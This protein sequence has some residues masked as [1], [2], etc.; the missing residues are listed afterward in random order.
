M[1][2][3]AE[4]RSLSIVCFARTL[5]TAPPGHFETLAELKCLPQSGHRCAEACE[6]GIP[7]QAYWLSSCWTI[8]M[9]H[10]ADS[11]IAEIYAVA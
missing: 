9:H 10:I 2:P 3:F 5:G 6:M 8:S 11:A 4:M 7:V 1:Q